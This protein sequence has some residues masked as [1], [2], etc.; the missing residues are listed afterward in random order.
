MRILS[1]DPGDAH[2]GVAISR[3]GVPETQTWEGDL[4]EA[5]TQFSSTVAWLEPDVV[6][7]EEFRLYP[8][9]AMEQG[10]SDFA[11]SQLIGAIKWYCYCHQRKLVM[12]QTANKKPAFAIMR[13]RGHVLPGKNQ[14]EKD[15]V[16][17]IY[18]YTKGIPWESSK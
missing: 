10:Y 6:L 18:H 11:T 5:M 13:G 9:L 17:H 7:L 4:C 15:A 12:T 3:G 8:W 1:I 16:A 14:H 2:T